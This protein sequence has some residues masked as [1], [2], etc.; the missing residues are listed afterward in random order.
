MGTGIVRDIGEGDR[1]RCCISGDDKRSHGIA[2]IAGGIGGD[3]MEGMRR[4]IGQRNRMA[5]GRTLDCSM[6]QQHRIVVHGDRCPLLKASGEQQGGIVRGLS[7]CQRTHH[8]PD[9]VGR[10][11]EGHDRRR[12]VTDDGY[13]QRCLTDVAGTIRGGGVE[14]VGGAVR[15]GGHVIPRCPGY[16]RLT[17]QG[18]AIVNLDG[19]IGFVGTCKR[20][21]CIV[22]G[23]T[24]HQGTGHR[25]HV[26]G[27]RGQGHRGRT[28]IHGYCKIGGWIADV[29]GGIGGGGTQ[30]VPGA[31]HARGGVAPGGAC[32]R[33]RTQRGI[34]IVYRDHG[35]GFGGTGKGQ[36]RIIALIS[37]LQR[38]R[39]RTRIIH[40]GGECD[41]W[42]H[43]ISHDGKV[44]GGITDIADPI[45][46]C[47]TKHVRC[48]VS[49][50]GDVA[51]CG[52]DYRR[53][54]QRRGTVEELNRA[55][56]FGGTGE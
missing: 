25:T 3:G 24:G 4:A 37:C 6:A 1:R 43:G 5:P 8:G 53:L 39:Y 52:P 56:R 38:A 15:Y 31:I 41:G 54:T 34:A 19:G 50:G 51:P 10:S 11:R 32:H 12:H 45:G 49:D 33:G 27:N 14:G 48:T 35:I 46:G 21:P 23:V 29:A 28:G 13:G 44:G 40:D 36:C 9:I 2:G 20:D 7:R 47:G 17:E 30:S 42:R 22:T 55:I 16:R 26:I 18:G